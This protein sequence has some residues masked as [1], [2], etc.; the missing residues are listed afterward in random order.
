MTEEE[1]REAWCPFARVWATDAEGGGG[2]A[3]INRYGDTAKTLHP[4]A[5]CLGS[6]CMAWRWI[7]RDRDDP[8]ERGPARRGRCGLAGPEGR[9]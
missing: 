8:Y 7:D 3:A 6:D 9:A 2:D 1:A 5:M 4:N